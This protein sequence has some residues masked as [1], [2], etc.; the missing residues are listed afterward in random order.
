LLTFGFAVLRR[1]VAVDLPAVLSDFDDALEERRVAIEM[2]PSIDD[3]DC[4]I[5][6]RKMLVYLAGLRVIASHLP[7]NSAYSAK[8]FSDF[9]Q[10][11]LIFVA[12]Q[13]FMIKRINIC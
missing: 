8:R 2:S 11:N 6:N 3:G 5:R 1:L 4:P 12:T 9:A 13:H 10:T 7:L